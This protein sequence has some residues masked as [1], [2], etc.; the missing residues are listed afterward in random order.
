MN[1]RKIL[2]DSFYELIQD[3]DVDDVTV[4]MIL[5]RSEISR[6]TFYRHYRDKYDLMNA[7][8]QSHITSALEK[9]DHGAPWAEVHAE[10]VQ[11]V[12]QNQK[13]YRRAFK[14]EGAESF[15]AFLEQFAFD[16]YASKLRQDEAGARGVDGKAPDEG[17]KAPDGQ[18]R[19][20]L[21]DEDRVALEILCG[22]HVATLK[23]WVGRGCDTPPDVMTRVGLAFMP[24]N[25]LNALNVKGDGDV[26]PVSPE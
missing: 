7:Y 4:Q 15:G 26:S 9:I 25:L 5:D 8:Y 20:A 1:T 24:Q 3:H 2:L 21:S 19:G 18:N 23:K 6:A 22:G 11:H 14:T 16:Y 13:Y 12:Y 10:I 17:D